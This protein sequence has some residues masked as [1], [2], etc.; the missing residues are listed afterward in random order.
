MALNLNKMKLIKY[1]LS[2]FKKEKDEYLEYLKKSTGRKWIK[3]IDES[4]LCEEKD[5]YLELDE[6]GN[7]ICTRDAR[8]LPYQTCNGPFCAWFTVPKQNV[9]LYVK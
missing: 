1:I 4:Y 3:Y 9:H 5:F 8:L 2:F 6:N 7:A